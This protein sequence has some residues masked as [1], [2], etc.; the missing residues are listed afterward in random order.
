MISQ[1]KNR[2][3]SC[4]VASYLNATIDEEA[5]TRYLQH[6]RQIGQGI[7][8][9]TDKYCRLCHAYVEEVMHMI[10]GRPNI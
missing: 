8:P 6:K 7:E 9:A 3:T 4:H 10:S 2:Y 1:S 5:S